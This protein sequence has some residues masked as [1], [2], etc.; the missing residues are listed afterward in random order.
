MDGSGTITPDNFKNTQKFV[1]S[2]QATIGL[3]NN[4]N[5][6]AVVTY[7]DVARKEIQCNTY[8]EMTYFKA[9][10]DNM[11]KHGSRTN[12]RDGLEK[13]QELLTSHGCGDGYAQK[14][15]V[16]LTD[17]IANVGK[18][19]EKGLVDAAKAIQDAGTIILVVAI[20]QFTDRQLLKM[21]DKKNIFR[22]DADMDGFSALIEDKF[23]NKVKTGICGNVKTT[24][25]YYSQ[26]YS[27]IFFSIQNVLKIEL[28]NINSCK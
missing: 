15:I 25:G 8:S 20:G 3:S 1:N 21:V 17:G 24:T 19:G 11:V 10:V 7:G 6:A 4:H 27:Y 23:I 22:T 5:K 13:G 28:L 14:I 9:A 26:N 2:I 18:G 12:T 16:L